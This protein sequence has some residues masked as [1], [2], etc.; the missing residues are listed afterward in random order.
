MKDDLGQNQQKTN[1]FLMVGQ[2]KKA[3]ISTEKWA[4]SSWGKELQTSLNQMKSMQPLSLTQ[5]KKN[6]KQNM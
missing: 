1:K 5:N 6:V 3:N 4:F 2:K